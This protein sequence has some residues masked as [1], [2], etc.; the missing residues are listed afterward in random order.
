MYRA[1]GSWIIINLILASCRGW[2]F[3]TTLWQT[4]HRWWLLGISC[5]SSWLLASFPFIA[6]VTGRDGLLYTNFWPEASLLSRLILILAIVAIPT[7]VYFL[8]RKLPTSTTL[9]IIVQFLLLGTG[10]FL[11]FS[12]T[13]WAGVASRVLIALIEER[14]KTTT[15]LAYNDTF[16]FL[17]SDI[18]FFWL[19]SAL[20]FACI[21]NIVYLRNLGHGSTISLISLVIKRML[22]SRVMHMSYTGMIAIGITYLTASTKK[23]LAGISLIWAGILLHTLFNSFLSSAHIGLTIL[24]IIFWYLFMSRL[25]YRSER[26]Y[27]S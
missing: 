8:V 3:R 16:S 23:Y 22:T 21:E 26:V 14:T 24:I 25:I 27:I 17:S 19:I 13:P 10:L 6:S 1:I 12:L 20:G 2:F 5:I 7:I 11:A 9:K 18:I 4:Q 15:S